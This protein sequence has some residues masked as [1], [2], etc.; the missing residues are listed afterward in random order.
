MPLRFEEDC[1]H[2][3]GHCV[4]D[5]ALPLLEFLKDAAI[6]EVE[7][8]ACDSMH[9]SLLQVLAAVRPKMLSLPTEPQLAGLVVSLGGG[10]AP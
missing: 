10:L 1:A 9:T 4:V 2:L 8:A 5:E 6:P 7:L 3:E